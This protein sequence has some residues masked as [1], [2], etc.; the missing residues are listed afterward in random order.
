MVEGEGDRLTT[1]IRFQ[2]R[3]RVR[4]GFRASLATHSMVLRIRV[5][6]RRHGRLREAID[7]SALGVG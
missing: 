6:V 5:E 7:L 4:V 1:R 2:V 3:W